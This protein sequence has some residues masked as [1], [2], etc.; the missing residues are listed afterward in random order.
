MSS[1]VSDAVVT[2]Y[3]GG[4]AGEKIGERQVGIVPAATPEAA[5]SASAAFTYTPGRLGRRTIYAKAQ[6]MINGKPRNFNFDMTLIVADEADLVKA[7]IDVGR[8]NSYVAGGSYAGKYMSLKELLASKNIDLVETEALDGTALSGASMLFI[9]APA[10]DIDAA[11]YSSAEIS[12]IKS[13]MAGGGNIIVTGNADYGER[14]AAYNTSKQSNAILEAIGSRLRLNDDETVEK[15]PSY[16]GGESQ[17]YRI[18]FK[19]YNN[20]VFPKLVENLSPNLENPDEPLPFS[21]YSGASVYQTDGA[22]LPS[23]KVGALID[24]FP[25]TAYLDSDGKGD[26]ASLMS[27]QIKALMAEELPGGGKIIVGGTTFYSDFEIDPTSREGYNNYNIINNIVNWF[28]PAARY[29]TVTIGQLRANKAEYM[30]KK[31]R[32]EGYVT[33]ESRAQSDQSGRDNAF[34]DV[35]YIQGLTGGIT[36]FGI[37]QSVLPLGFKVMVQGTVGEYE[38]DFQIQVS[39]ETADV[40]VLDYVEQQIKPVHISTGASMRTPVEGMLVE[41]IGKVTRMNDT[42][43][44]IDDGSGES[45]VYLNGYIG[46]RNSE[47]GFY[48]KWDSRI[49]AGDVV[50]AIG[51]ASVDPEGHRLRVRDSKEISL[52]SKGSVIDNIPLLPAPGSAIGN[53]GVSSGGGGFGGGAGTGGNI[54]VSAIFDILGVKPPF[55][56]IENHWAR[57][58]IFPLIGGG[59]FKGYEDGS[60]KPDINITRAEFITLLYRLSN[61]AKSG[62]DKKFNDVNIGDWYYDAVMYGAEKG[63]VMGDNSGNFNPGNPVTREEMAVFT[64]RYSGGGIDSVNADTSVFNDFGD[65]A[66]WAEESVIWGNEFGVIKGDNG[67][68]HPKN[69]A[70]R[71]EAAVIISRILKRVQTSGGAENDND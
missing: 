60:F 59:I 22:G 30:G 54:P 20:T 52:L 9:A 49:A 69:N 41:V 27:S 29:E 26:A 55:A 35:I 44:F 2:L 68:F 45:R 42:S 36:V 46:S 5:G 37:S 31:V 63:I 50:S 66:D 70:T 62:A 14:S 38:G 61:S 25:T 28:K 43:L 39:N 65:I 10:A 18:Y 40:L 3:D 12:A 23:S 17:E 11:A 7:V 53:N 21:F 13:Y 67:N 57:D 47:T 71:A 64:A 19:N 32:V 33:S 58:E 51:L 56:D 48:G 15:D 16:N 4:E 1:A 24:A 6:M 34:F 8:K